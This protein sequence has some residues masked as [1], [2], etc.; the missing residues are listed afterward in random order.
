MSPRCAPSNPSQ[1]PSDTRL[2]RAPPPPQAGEAK[3]RAATFD[4]FP[5]SAPLSFRVMDAPVTAPVKRPSTIDRQEMERALERGPYTEEGVHVVDQMIRDRAKGLRSMRIWPLIRPALYAFLGYGKAKPMCDRVYHRSADE[6]FSMV[7]DELGLKVD[8]EGLENIPK[9]GP[10]ILAPNHPT[11]LSDGIAMHHMLRNVR[12]D[13]MVFANRDA[14]KVAPRLRDYII[15]V[16]WVKAGETRDF[17]GSR[18]T[19]VATLRAVKAGMGLVLFPSGRISFHADGRLNEQPWLPTVISF[20]RRFECPVIPMR[21]DARNSWF[22]YWAWN[23]SAE[24]RDMT[25]FHEL[26][27]K[28][29]STFR[30]KIGEPLAPADIPHESETEAAWS[31]QCYVEHDLGAGKSWAER[32]PTPPG[33]PPARD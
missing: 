5:P 32:S 8:V 19:L 9:D 33:P 22:Y 24:L 30:M 21:I 10:F 1:A 20:Q 28:A 23:T 3:R 31:L 16:E 14:Y 27:N 29:G 26:L 2:R 11:G 12:P 13:H 4:F 17:A 15:P 7:R 6:V 18:D 25:I